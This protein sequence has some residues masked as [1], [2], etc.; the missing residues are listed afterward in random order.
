M[1]HR[2]QWSNLVSGSAIVRIAVFVSALGL[3]SATPSLATDGPVAHYPFDGNTDDASGFGNHAVSMGA[4][5]TADRF[6][7]PN[8]AVVVGSTGHLEAADSSSLDIT[9]AFTI[10]A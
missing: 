5:L 1:L 9:D 2:R 3:L 4:V 10:S 6:G 8:S 7:S